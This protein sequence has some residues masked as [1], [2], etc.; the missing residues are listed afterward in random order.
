[1]RRR[2]DE[3]NAALQSIACADP[4][5][6][7]TAVDAARELDRR[8]L[9]RDSPSRPGKPLRDLLRAGQVPGA[10]QEAG[11]WWRIRCVG[12]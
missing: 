12:P 5:G 2:V 7:V 10:Y 1:M 4:S 8:G 3:I 6:E 11:R 9:L